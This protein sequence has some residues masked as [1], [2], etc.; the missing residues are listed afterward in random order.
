MTLRC[1]LLLTFSIPFLAPVSQ[2]TSKSRPAQTNYVFY[3]AGTNKLESIKSN[4][5]VS[6]LVHLNLWRS[7]GPLKVNWTDWRMSND[8]FVAPAI[9]GQSQELYIAINCNN[10]LIN[11]SSSQLSWKGWLEPQYEFEKELVEDFCNQIF[12]RQ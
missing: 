5:T 10:Q 2:A 1:F 9:N 8:S 3:P 4:Y 6:G 7:Y 11:I 12:I